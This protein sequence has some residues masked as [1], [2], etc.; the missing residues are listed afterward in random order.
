ME[1]TA[2]FEL[3]QCA[4]HVWA[5][6]SNLS[7]QPELVEHY[8]RQLSETEINRADR[9][10][11]KRLQERFVLTHA[12]LRQVL[13]R[14]LKTEAAHLQF[15][16]TRLARPYLPDFEDIDFN[17]SHTT[18]M[19][20]IAVSRV[21]VGADIEF[22]CDAIKVQSVGKRVLNEREYATVKNTTKPSE[23]H[24]FDYWTLKEAYSKATGQGLQMEFRDI[25]IELGTT[26][27]VGLQKT[28]DDSRNWGFEL[29]GNDNYRIAIATKQSDAR[30]VA[31]NLV[32]MNPD[33]RIR[34]PLGVR[35]LGRSAIT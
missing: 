13:S 8:R 29:Y 11:T 25:D 24:F 18:G 30:N 4:V 7:L 14:Y 2:A 16:E 5:I 26:I 15:A 12:M 17:M 21:P 35:L 27:T 34:G 28:N 6:K 20:I 32:E 3:D 22:R 31:L 19:S 23:N 10:R 1:Q 9:L 33:F